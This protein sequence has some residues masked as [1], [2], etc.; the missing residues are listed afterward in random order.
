MRQLNIGPRLGLAFGS[1]LAVL[2]GIA[3]LSL[4]QLARL[5]DRVEL[6]VRDYYPKVAMT[7]RAFEQV[8]N[9]SVHLRNLALVADPAGA[10]RE[11]GALDAAEADANALLS[12]FAARVSTAKGREVLAGLMAAKRAYEADRGAY[13]ALLARDERQAATELLLGRLGASLAAYE[14]R[15][16]LLNRLG[17]TLMNKSADEAS[18]VYHGSVTSIAAMTLAALLLASVLAYRIARGIT[19]P[20]RLAVDAAATI[21]T[22]NLA[23]TIDC[24]STDET[25]RL[26]QSLKTM[27]A[28]LVNIVGGVRVN[29]EAIADGAREIADGTVDLSARTEQQAGSL[30]ETASAMEELTGTVRQSAATARDAFDVARGAAAVAERS[31]AQVRQ[32]VERMAAIDESSRRIGNIIGVIDGIAFQTN[33]LALNAAVEAARAG[34]QGRGFAVVASE[35]RNLAQR[36]ASAAHEIKVLIADSVDK[37]AAGNDFAREAGA[38]MDA[39]LAEIRRVAM[40]MSDI[41]AAGREQTIG[42]EQ[43]NQ[44]IGQMDHV[45]QQNAALVEEAA[46]AAASMRERTE[47]LRAAVRIFV[48]DEARAAPAPARTVPL[49]LA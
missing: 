26:L 44:A 42:I 19:V 31:G 16:A 11:R 14:E 17:G 15:M 37:V 24:G 1:L 2:A 4:I 48:L 7:G 46:A 18:E 41:E 47:A 38:T 20:L 3:W 32:V 8:K 22:G 36:S 23:V 27:N 43:I 25:G 39:V 35:V 12:D 6:V 28:S 13:L 9:T 45:T 49:R 30:E 10:L 33:I 21:A 29:A 5:H 34:E 40:L